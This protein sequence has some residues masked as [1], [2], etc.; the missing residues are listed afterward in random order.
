MHFSI[1]L[2]GNSVSEKGFDNLE[3]SSRAVGNDFDI[4]PFAAITP[5]TVDKTMSYEKVNWNWPWEREEIDFATGLTKKPYPTKN[6]KARMACAMSHYLLWMHVSESNESALITEHD[7]VFVERIDFD[8]DGLGVPI[9]GINNPMGA[10][11]RPHDYHATV[12]A[13][14]RDILLSPNIDD[15]CVPQGLAGNSAYFISPAGA[16][17]M[18]ECVKQFGLWP[19]DAIMCRQ[20]VSRLSVTKR[21]YTQVQGLRS[22]TTQ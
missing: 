16:D 4:V 9:L 17:R 22:T 6:Q 3:S 8:F 14:K 21:Y 12:M 11:R 5:E 18:L 10:T 13:S 20:L 1:V 19:N 2:E 7:A 15:P